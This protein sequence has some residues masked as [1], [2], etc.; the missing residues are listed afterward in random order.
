MLCVRILLALLMPPKPETLCRHFYI[1]T[2]PSYHCSSWQRGKLNQNAKDTLRAKTHIPTNTSIQCCLKVGPPSKTVAQ[3]LN[4]IGLRCLHVLSTNVIIRLT[5]DHVP[6]HVLQHGAV[7]LSWK[8]KNCTIAQYI[9]W[10][11]RDCKSLRSVFSVVTF[12][13]AKLFRRLPHLGARR[14]HLQ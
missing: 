5:K 6:G 8:S 7:K 1:Q 10:T 11:I 9:G 12:V 2:S 13:L 3:L 4:N 14:V